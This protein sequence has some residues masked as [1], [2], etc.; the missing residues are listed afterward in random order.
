MHNYIFDLDGTL[1]NSSEE[2]LLCLKKAFKTVGYEI[3]E[4]KFTADIIGPPINNIIVNV[5]PELIDS[6]VSEQIMKSFRQIYD[7]DK[8]DISVLYD[9]V[10]DFVYGLKKAGKKLFIA[11]FKPK[12]PT[13]RLVAKFFPNIFDDIYTID[14]F[15]KPITKEEMLKDI[16]LRYNLDKS[17]T[18]MI[19]DSISDMIAGKSAGITSV[20]V[21]WGYG[22][23]KT[24]LLENADYTINKLEEME[25]Q[26]LNYQTI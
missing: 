22:F 21:L 1:V 20:G 16:I 2:I 9:G 11:T 7:Y 6:E 5:A 19:G 18:V 10:Y 13:M 17:E 15:E 14:K 8:N 4:S 24:K 23:D 12:I 3:E 25:C 26:K